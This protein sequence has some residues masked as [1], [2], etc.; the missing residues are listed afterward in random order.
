MKPYVTRRAFLGIASGALLSPLYSSA[1]EIAGVT[2]PDTARPE[3]SNSELRL[4]GGGT[5]RFLF[6]RY[7]VCG[8]YVIEELRDA[9]A[10]LASDTVR[11]MQLVAIRRIS[12]FEFLWGL[13]Q[14]LA[15]NLSEAESIALR[16]PLEQ[17]RASIRTIGAIARGSRVY[18]DYVPG[19]GTGILVDDLARAMPIPGKPLNDALMRVWIGKRPLDATLKKALLGA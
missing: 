10:I 13:D 1:K 19:M 6:L 11:R 8:L 17:V 3:G 5:F 15:D 7:Y 9:A 14:G 2:L 12:S 16:I 18:I 4:L